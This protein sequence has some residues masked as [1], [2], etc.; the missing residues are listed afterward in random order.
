MAGLRSV[1]NKLL[2][3]KK[4]V[5]VWGKEDDKNPIPKR[6]LILLT[7]D[8]AHTLNCTD[9]VTKKVEE[10]KEYRFV[11]DNDV[12]SKKVKIVDVLLDDKK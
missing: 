12:A 10:F 5:G 2:V 1:T 7:E 8:G 4:I 9:D 3:V 11:I 6:Q